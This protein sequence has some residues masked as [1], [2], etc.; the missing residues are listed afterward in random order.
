M[1]ENIKKHGHFSTNG[2]EIRLAVDMLRRFM[3]QRINT[4][5][6]MYQLNREI[7]E[8]QAQL[9]GAEWPWP[10]LVDDNAN[11]DA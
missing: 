5:T 4:R 9:D 3:K 2:Q 1:D 7:A 11:E 6:T 8:A 10:R